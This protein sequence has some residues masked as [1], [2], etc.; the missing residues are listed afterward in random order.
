VSNAYHIR[1]LADGS[2]VVVRRTPHGWDHFDTNDSLLRSGG[3]Q[4]NPF[5]VEVDGNSVWV[6]HPTLDRIYEYNLTTGLLVNTIVENNPTGLCFF[7]GVLHCVT[8]SG[9]FKA[10]GGATYLTGLGAVQDLEMGYDLLGRQILV[11][12][13]AS[14]VSYYIEASSLPIDLDSFEARLVGKNAVV[15]VITATEAKNRLMFLE[16][17]TDNTTF[18]AIDSLPGGGT[19]TEKRYYRFEVAGL[20][21]GANY[22]RLRQVDLDGTFTFTYSPIRVLTV[23]GEEVIAAIFPNPA[24]AGG[25]VTVV[26]SSEDATIEVVDLGGRI[27]QTINVAGT[28]ATLASL[29]AGSYFVRV[30][31]AVGPVITKKLIVTQGA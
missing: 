19:T 27:L 26:T 28:T 24:P 2:Y 12:T 15:E 23:E 17:R 10:V 13:T 20:A 9:Q 5:G 3:G 21:V 7:E 29:P 16:H 8:S 18:E 30:I 25:E 4:I 14:A 1:Y 11:I 22:F 31:P 6:S